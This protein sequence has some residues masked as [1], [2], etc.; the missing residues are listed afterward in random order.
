MNGKYATSETY[1]HVKYISTHILRR[2]AGQN[3]RRLGCEQ[4]KAFLPAQN[5]AGAVVYRG[6]DILAHVGE[7]QL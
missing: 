7:P 2:E 4:G 5:V 3:I 1:L 6:W